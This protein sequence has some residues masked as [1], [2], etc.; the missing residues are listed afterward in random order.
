MKDK[1]QGA[2]NVGVDADV[3]LRVRMMLIEIRKKAPACPHNGECDDDPCIYVLA[4]R[5]LREL[6]LLKKPKV[7]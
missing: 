7:T 6:N 5:V 3:M 1:K 4:G 2:F